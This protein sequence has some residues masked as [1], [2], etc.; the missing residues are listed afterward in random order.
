MYITNP[1]YS[2][3]ILCKL[4]ILYN[5]FFIYRYSIETDPS[6]CCDVLFGIFAEFILEYLLL[7]RYMKLNANIFVSDNIAG[8]PRNRLQKKFTV[9]NC[10]IDIRY[11]AREFR[12]KNRIMNLEFSK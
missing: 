5:H 7:D 1:I 9:E 11:T 8:V 3:G 12:S 6:Y 4:S 2:V 10:V